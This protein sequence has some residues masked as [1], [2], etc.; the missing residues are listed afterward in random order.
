M[1][2]L[3][4]ILLLFASAMV[5]S[6]VETTNYTCIVCGKGPLH[7]RIWLSKWG[8][9]C[10]DCYRLENHCSLCGLPM[11]DG[12][13]PA[14]TGDGR[15]ICKFDRPNAVLDVGEAREV[16]TSTRRDLVEL[17]GRG[18]ALNFPDVTVNLFDVDYWSE[19]GREDGLHKFGFSYT[20]KSRKGNCTHE[21]VLLSGRL[22]A[23]LAAT[24]AHEYTHLWINEIHPT[25][26]AI[27]GDTIEAICELSAYKLLESRSQ[28][29][30][31]QKILNNPY[32]H[33]E[34]KELVA[35]EKEN[36]MGYILN[37]V[38]NGSTTRLVSAAAARLAPVKPRTIASTNIPPPLPE[39]LKLGG[40][41]LD[42]QSRHAIINGMSF[43]AGETKSI[44]L[45]DRVLSVRC[46]EIHRNEAVLEIDGLLNFI[47]L[48]IG[49][50]KFVP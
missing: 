20:R 22:R 40:L 32:T 21:V 9:V 35:L 46:R 4:L 39:A 26:H 29:E 41:L 18:I 36:G 25:E 19:K 30:Q 33:G 14:K 17:F 43:A 44:S 48:K 37:W 3:A 7:G 10:G 24:A 47:T 8:A 49:E 28:P 11:R 38:K 27:D 50:E 6:A 13:N 5:S 31:Q 34:I 12:D 23:E 1:R 2:R 15:F 42:G 16:F 45:L